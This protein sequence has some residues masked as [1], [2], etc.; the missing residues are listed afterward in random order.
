MIRI[1]LLG[2][3]RAKSRTVLLDVGQTVA[4]ASAA[5]V[6]VTMLGLGWWAWSLS[7]A[8]TRVDSEIAAAQQEATRLQAVLAEV[9]NF[10]I[11][12]TQL[13]QRVGIIQQLR[14]G[15]S[16]PVRLLD[17]V[18][19]SLPDLMW[20]TQLQQEAGEVTIQGLSSTLVDV[21]DFIGNL[22]AGDLFE[23]PIQLI[24]SQV[25]DSN[26]REGGAELIQFTVR[27]RMAPLEPVAGVATP[28]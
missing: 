16:V 21:S 15:Q 3:E 9:Q 13:Q 1:N 23:R 2:V 8:S 7:S 27:A 10:E 24:D 14:Q 17:H 20:L 4:V 28:Q 26:A 11:R 18:S 6:L 25:Q 5:V 19:Q 22:G 12:R